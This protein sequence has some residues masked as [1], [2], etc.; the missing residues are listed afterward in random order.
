MMELPQHDP[1]THRVVIKSDGTVERI[2]LT[3]EE[4]KETLAEWRK[5][6]IEQ[7][8]QRQFDAAVTM[9]FQTA[10]GWFL[11]ID[12]GARQ[13]LTELR[14]QITEG[15]SME[16]WKPGDV[17][18]V[19]IRDTE[20]GYHELTIAQVRTLS[21]QGGIYYAQL[22]QQFRQVVEQAPA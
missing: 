21:F 22:L 20:G 18:P 10:D 14:T 2:D 19:K 3:P 8:Q 4:V 5:N 12:D 6:D 17:C 16:V 13:Q 11:P 9:G 1:P 7:F 15:L